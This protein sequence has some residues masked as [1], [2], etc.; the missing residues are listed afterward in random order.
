MLTPGY[1]V[2]SDAQRGF[3]LAK[4]ALDGRV[5]AVTGATGG[6]GTRLCHALAAAGAT[7]VPIAR[8][9]RKLD[10]LHDALVDAGAAR[11]ALVPFALETA[12]EAEYDTLATLL[13]DE[14]GGLDALVHTAAAFVAPMPMATIAQS[15][16]TRTMNVNLT[17]ARLAT[18]GCLPLL[19]VSPLASVTFLLDHKPGAYW[20][21]YGVSKQAVHALM[22][23]LADENEGRRDANGHPSLA[24]N[25]YDPGPMRTPLRRRAFPGELER[26]APSPDERLGPL[27]ALIARHER[28]LTGTALRHGGNER[29]TDPGRSRPSGS[30]PSEP[31]ATFAL[32]LLQHA[33]TPLDVAASLARLDEAAREAAAAGARLLVVPEASLT[34][35]NVSPDEARA[36]AESADGAAFE[37]VAAICRGH[38]IAILYGFVERDHEGGGESAMSWNTVQLVERDGTA[39][40]R[41]RKTHLWGALDRSMFAP[42]ED[43]APLVTLDGWRVGLLI[44]YDVEFPEAV[45]RL[46]LEGAELV[47]VPTALMAPFTF[48]ADHLVRVRAG[49]ERRVSWP[50]ANYC[51]EENGLGYVGRSAIV[52]PGGEELA[53]AAAAPALLHARLERTALGEA[54]AA[55]PYLRERR[56]ELYTPRRT[57][58]APRGPAPRE[59][60]EP[61]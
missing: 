39:L 45:R 60:E 6:L 7:L 37:R 1:V 14:L 17:A 55:L 15:E 32:A 47:L 33:P 9:E 28:A 54:R 29:M 38:G 12:T 2:A 27:L 24:I 41:Y 61:R 43:L 21:A 4:G 49:R 3:H 16:W 46:A 48:V 26:E 8:A 31:S 13:G 56:A 59:E 34:G 57:A 11:P 36:V 18:L 42:G 58:N 30:R 53:R 5:V 50:Y 40:A 35:Y 19:R 10:R 44:C 23:M 51:G 52:G 25:G 22:H 20:G